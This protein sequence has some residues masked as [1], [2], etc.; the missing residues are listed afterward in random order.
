MHKAVFLDRDGTL[1]RNT[2]YLIDFKDF[3]L[4]PGVLEGLHLLQKMGYRLFVVSN[5]S[6]VARGFFTLDQVMDLNEK[7][8]DF[9]AAHGITIEDMVICPHHP[10]GQVA[11]FSRK[12]FCRKPK[13]GMIS[14]LAKHYHLDVTQSYMAGDREL[15]ARAG[16]SAGTQGVLIAPNPSESR[17]EP[18]VEIP[19]F[20]SLLAF[21]QSLQSHD[22][23][24]SPPKAH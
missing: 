18:H 7:I 10:N 5:Q 1:N 12:C 24:F 17:S 11:E 8:R 22:M 19:V 21:A 13:P 14:W 20:P 15:D 9:F 23:G 3:E 4:L 16:I 2:E 6:G